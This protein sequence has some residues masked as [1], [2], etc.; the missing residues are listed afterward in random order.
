MFG[1]VQSIPVQIG[2]LLQDHE[3]KLI[4]WELILWELILWTQIM[5]YKLSRCIED[6]SSHV[7]K[8][9]VTH[10]KNRVTEV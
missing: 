7:H 6:F 10:M 4:L 2:I 9:G 1:K 8:P 3:I 5:G